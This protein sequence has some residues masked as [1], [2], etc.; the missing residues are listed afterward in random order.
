MEHDSLNTMY[1]TGYS[2][3]MV[4]T[5]LEQNIL[6]PKIKLKNSITALDFIIIH[7]HLYGCQKLCMTVM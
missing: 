2:N 5:C 6:L 7:N 1:R 3:T 4:T